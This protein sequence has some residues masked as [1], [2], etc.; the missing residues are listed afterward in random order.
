MALA[1][2]YSVLWHGLH[3]VAF[4][5]TKVSS[6]EKNLSAVGATSVISSMIVSIGARFADPFCH[7]S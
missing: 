6:P 2:T 5:S 1:L 3:V 4:C 7:H